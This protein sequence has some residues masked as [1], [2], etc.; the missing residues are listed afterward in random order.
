MAF[1]PVF[2]FDPAELARLR[3]LPCDRRISAAA[4]A[5]DDVLSTRQLH[6]LGIDG[7]A[8]KRRAA[9]RQLFPR[10]RGVH[11]VGREGLS[12]RGE[13]RAA[14]LRCGRRAVLSHRTAARLQDLPGAAGPV[15][16]TSTAHFRPPGRESGVVVHFTDRWRPGEVTW[17]A[18]F[19]CTSLARTLA[20]LAGADEGDFS[21]VW[22]AA[23]QRLLLDAGPL[24]AQVGR[25]RASVA[26]LRARLDRREEAPPTESEL[27]DVFA[28]V[29]RRAGIGPLDFQWPIQLNGRV[30]RIDVVL[31]RE[32]IAIE[33]DSRRWHAQQ[34]AFASDREKD[35]S[36]REAGWVIDGRLCVRSH[37]DPNAEPAWR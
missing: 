25:R 36:L 2:D 21:K 16:V 32:R 34:A 9:R 23:D 6:A 11:A 35:L 27:E 19:P 26:V 31:A 37:S 4:A 17:V 3:L 8:I 7:A 33:L 5:R 18:G 28:G 14:L 1:H 13:I 29:C 15:E 24:R 30:G 20:D 10:H 12:V 22:N